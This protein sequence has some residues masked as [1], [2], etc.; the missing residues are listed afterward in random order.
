ML[1]KTQTFLVAGL[2][3]V[4]ISAPAHA[5]DNYENI[6]AGYYAGPSVSGTMGFAHLFSNFPIA[7]EGEV[8][9]SWT[10]PGDAVRVRHVFI[11]DTTT[12]DDDAQKDGSIWDVGINAVYPLNES[13]GPVKFFVFAGPRYAHYDGHFEY[14]NGNEDFDIT[15]NSWGLGGGLRGVLPLSQRFN[16]VMQLGLDYY[17]PTSIY[18]HDATYYP[19]NNNINARTENN[20]TFT[21]ADAASAT[22]VPR[23]RPRVMIGLQW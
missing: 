19:N 2:A 9:H 7:F 18:G 11:N 3:A 1:T 6:L 23:L 10:D 21:Y 5:W 16:A 22:N 17:F 4:A 15:A 13:Y 14:V 20:Y 8:G 12:G